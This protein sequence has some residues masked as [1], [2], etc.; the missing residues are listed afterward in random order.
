MTS[1][2]RVPEQVAGSLGFMPEPQFLRATDRGPL[3]TYSPGAPAS[4]S[5]GNLL[6]CKSRAIPDPKFEPAQEIGFPGDSDAY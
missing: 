2:A 4:E 5:Q 3:T 1:R 6:K